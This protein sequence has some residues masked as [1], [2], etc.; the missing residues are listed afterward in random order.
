MYHAARNSCMLLWIKETIPI[1]RKV[2]EYSVIWSKPMKTLSSQ[3][4][5]SDNWLYSNKWSSFK[6]LCRATFP[7]SE[8]ISLKDFSSTYCFVFVLSAVCRLLWLW[9]KMNWTMSLY[10]LVLD[11]GKLFDCPSFHKIQ[12]NRR[13]K[14]TFASSSSSLVY[15]WACKFDTSSLLRNLR[16]NCCLST[17]LNPVISACRSSWSPPRSSSAFEIRVVINTQQLLKLFLLKISYISE[18]SPLRYSS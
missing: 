16:I 6:R 18:S 2:S 8:R 13:S 5:E 4:T 15:K 11:S 10:N 17:L 3:R 1:G 7:I 9:F 12:N 14:G